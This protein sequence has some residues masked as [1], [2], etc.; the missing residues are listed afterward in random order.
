[1]GTGLGAGGEAGDAKVVVGTGRVVA[2]YSDLGTSRPGQLGESKE[3][4]GGGGIYRECDIAVTG[5]AM[6]SH[7]GLNSAGVGSLLLNNTHSR[8]GERRSYMCRDRT[9]SVCL[10]QTRSLSYVACG[11]WWWWW[12]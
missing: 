10:A 2:T 9:S 6:V 1:M 7:A 4:E 3:E 11:Q 5:V 8:R 12:W